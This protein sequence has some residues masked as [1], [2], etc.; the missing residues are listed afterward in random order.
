MKVKSPTPVSGP[1]LATAGIMLA[2]LAIVASWAG[3][4]GKA[5]WFWLGACFAGELLWVRLP[6]GRATLS[7]ASACNFA[8]LLV[9]PRAEAML[10]AAAAGLVAE[11]VVLRKHPTRFLYN[12]GHAA[13]AVGAGSI[14]YHSL[15][16]PETTLL[17]G[18]SPA[19]LVPLI[20]AALTYTLI[21]TGAV[22]L[23]VGLTERVS[24][25]RAWWANFGSLYELL[26]NSA[27]FSLGALLALL[28]ALGGALG[29]VLVSGPLL[30]AHES[31]RRY[32]TRQQK[33]GLTS[34]L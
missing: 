12:A 11:A 2:T 19:G 14:V 30:L 33:D 1:L 15:A 24:P 27:L 8:A 18:F 20:A 22:S 16:G 34:A 28:Y 6:L 7:M 25:W 5:W 29:T 23:A 9:L 13:L 17:A 21:N 26:S 4:F 3:P 32:T 31:Y 10:A